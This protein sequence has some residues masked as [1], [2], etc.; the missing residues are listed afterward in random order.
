MVMSPPAQRDRGNAGATASGRQAP[1]IQDA[2]NVA[3]LLVE[4]F[5]LIDAVLLC[6]SVARGD[7]DEWSD[8]DLVVIGSDPKLTPGRLRSAL[9]EHSDCVSLVYYPTSRFRKL[10]EDH[11]LVIVHFQKEGVAVYDPLDLLKR[12]LDRP[13]VPKVDFMKEIKAYRARLAPYTDPRR[14]NNWSSS[15]YLGPQHFLFC[16]FNL[17]SIGK[18][19]IMLG[20][21]RRGVYEFNREAAFQQFANLNPD[22][23]NETKRITQL[24]PFYRLMTG[25]QPEPLPFSY[26]SAVSQMREAVRAIEMVAKRVETQ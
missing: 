18:G 4:G 22:L 13:F 23:R 9:P 17:Y 19:F 2:E 16:L 11:A 12:I 10:C 5:P 24:R 7:A 25:R 20:L 3:R 1:T 21:A 8:L 6:G 14:F 26:E 15:T